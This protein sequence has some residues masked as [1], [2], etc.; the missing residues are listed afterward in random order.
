MFAPEIARGSAMLS[1]AQMARIDVERL[2]MSN[3]F[4]CVLGQL[5]GDFLTVRK[6]NLWS[7]RDAVYYGFAMAGD[8]SISDWEE[9]RLWAELT[10]QWQAEIYRR[11]LCPL[12]TIRGNL[13]H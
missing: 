12:D 2:E 10:K 1:D 5:F 11:S 7:F 8:D 4:H 6:A 9:A 13:L 3:C